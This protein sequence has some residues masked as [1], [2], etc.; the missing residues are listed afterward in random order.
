MYAEWVGGRRE[1]GGMV[2]GRGRKKERSVCMHARLACYLR[3]VHI[4]GMVC[5]VM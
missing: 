4:Q 2:T 5:D 1:S 3:V